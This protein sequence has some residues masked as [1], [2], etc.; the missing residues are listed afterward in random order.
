[1]PGLSYTRLDVKTSEC[2]NSDGDYTFGLPYWHS[3]GLGENRPGSCGV[4]AGSYAADVTDVVIDPRHLPGEAPALV[5][6][7]LSCWRASPL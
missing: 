7:A 4:L 1:V 2:G 5:P 6:A 3:T